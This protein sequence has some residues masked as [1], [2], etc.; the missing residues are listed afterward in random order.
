MPRGKEISEDIRKKAV[1]AHQSGEGF[2]TISKRFQLHPSTEKRCCCSNETLDA[3]LRQGD[4]VGHLGKS[5]D[6][7]ENDGVT[8][9]WSKA[10]DKVHGDVRPRSPENRERMEEP[11]WMYSKCL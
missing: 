10:S 7:R 5:V 8:S 2:K 3:A 6:H 11:G 9:G 1:T 4:E